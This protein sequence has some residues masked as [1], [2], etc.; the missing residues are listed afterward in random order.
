MTTRTIRYYE[1]RGSS[2]RPAKGSIACSARATA[3]DSNLR[4]EVA[5]RVFRSI[6]VKELFD[7]Y[8]VSKDECQQLEVFRDKLDSVKRF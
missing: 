1:T 7:L 3:R 2:V 4:F 6:K 8:D 5:S